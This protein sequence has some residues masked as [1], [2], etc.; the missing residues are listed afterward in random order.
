ME[1]K[2]TFLGVLLPSIPDYVSYSWLAMAILIVT[3]LILRK[4]ISIV[5]SGFQNVAELIVGFFLNLA[6]TNIDDYW[7]GKFYPLLGTLGLYILVCNLMGLIPGF[8]APTSN[9]NTTASMAIP[10]FLIYQFYGVKVHRIKYIKHFLGPIRS[11]YALPLMVLMFIIET[12]SHFVRPV[13]LTIRLFGNMMA[14]HK[15]MIIMGIL[16]PAV[17]PVGVLGLGLLLGV[18]Q[19]YV[20]VLLTS[21]YLAGAVEEA[22]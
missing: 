9:I 1:E 13:T 8:I 5:P 15:L 14:K 16:A 6:K 22:H 3:A 11:V 17:V 19:A 4:K 20:F 12:I 7:G 18:I 21:L 10:V 2:V